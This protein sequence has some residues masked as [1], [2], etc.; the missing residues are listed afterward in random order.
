MQ[1]KFRYKLIRSFRNV[2]CDCL[3]EAAHRFLVIWRNASISFNQNLFVL[4]QFSSG[5]GNALARNHIKNVQTYGMQGFQIARVRAPLVALVAA[6]SISSYTANLRHFFLF[7]A[8]ATSF[9]A[10]AFAR[11]QNWEFSR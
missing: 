6:L 11:T 9:F 10:Q 4:G 2:I 5:Y 1:D 8:Q 3:H 7:K